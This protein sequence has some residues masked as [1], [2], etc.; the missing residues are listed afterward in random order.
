MNKGNIEEIHKTAKDLEIIAA[1]DPKEHN[2]NDEVKNI[3]GKAVNWASDYIKGG[4]GGAGS[5]V[6]IIIVAGLVYHFGDKLK[7]SKGGKN[8]K[9]IEEGKQTNITVIAETNS[10]TPMNKLTKQDKIRNNN[11]YQRQIYNKPHAPEWEG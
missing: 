3:F 7:C 9:D 10:W 5:L 2:I 11:E 4:V 8:K 6:I 1:K